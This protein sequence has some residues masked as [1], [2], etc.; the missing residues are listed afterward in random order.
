MNERVELLDKALIF[1]GVQ[2]QV[3]QQLR[4]LQ[5]K[6]SLDSTNSALRRL[7]LEEQHATVVLAEHQSAGRGRLGRQWHSPFASNLY[8]SL[9][10]RFE[11]PLSELGCLPLVV[12][13]A[14][15][16]ALQRAGLDGHR[17]K[18]PND[19]LLDGRK[20]C[21][22]LVEMQG[23][24]QGPYQVVLGVGVNVNMPHEEAA[25]VIDQPWTDLQSRLPGL[26]RNSL[27]AMLVDELFGHIQS[28]AG[29]G[30]APFKERW[31]QMDALIGKT[32]STQDGHDQIEGIAL[33]VDDDGALLLDIG[34]KVLKLHSGE[35]SL[36]KTK[37]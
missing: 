9:G 4:D 27:A 7:P 28:F 26:S 5:V 11:Q 3:A 2:P 14:T 37:I 29:Q 36:N 23:D 35:V 10:W 12:A 17:V 25:G 30:F 22:C 18:W 31:K 6:T 1:A 34:D 21:G 8:L 16:D 24:A 19:I 32:I 13:L 20:L 15:A 33:G